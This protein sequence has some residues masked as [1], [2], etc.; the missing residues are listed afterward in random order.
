MH[1]AREKYTSELVAKAL[2]MTT[3]LT[4]EATRRAAALLVT[5]E[6]NDHRKPSGANTPP[7]PPSLGP[8]R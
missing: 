6:T 8:S 2:G 3:T 7:R 5:L 4:P 1:N